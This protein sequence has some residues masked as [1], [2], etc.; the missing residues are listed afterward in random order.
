MTNSISII[1][2]KLNM[3]EQSIEIPYEATMG[4]PYDHGTRNRNSAHGY[5]QA[6]EFARKLESTDFLEVVQKGV[7]L[8]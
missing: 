4:H 5:F 2:A 7:S 3:E 1:Y 8:R 6:R